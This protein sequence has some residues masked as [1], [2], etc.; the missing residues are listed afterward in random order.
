M[1]IR[2]VCLA[3]LALVFAAAPVSAND[4]IL[5][6]ALR[7]VLPNGAVVILNEK[8]EVPLVGFRVML[9][10]GAVTDPVG[11][12]GLAAL[13]A[14][15]LEK[16]AADLDAAAFAEAVDSVGGRLHASGG[17]EAITIAG[18][19]LA[20]DSGLMV[21]LLSDML[22]KPA[23]S[24]EEF[25]KLRER[26]INAIRAAKDSDPAELLPEY[27]DAYLFGDHPYG[28][29]SGGSEQSLAAITHADVQGFYERQMGGDRL[30]IVISGDIDAAAMQPVL[31][32]AF[33]DWRPAAGSL[34]E[35]PAPAPQP[36]GRLLLVDKPGAT[37]TYFWLGN[38]GVARDFDRRAE[39]EL[40][41]THFGGRFTS[42]LN[43]ALRVES[44]LTYGAGSYLMQPSRP[45]SVAISS[46]TR[47]DATVEAIDMAI[48]VLGRLHNSNFAAE[49]IDSARNYVLGQFPIQL[50]TAADLAAQ[51]AEL[52][53]YGLPAETIDGYGDAL[54]AA[55]PESI[56]AVI[57]D[58]YPLPEELVFV[59]IGDAEAIRE[60]VARYGEVTEIT[61]SLPVFRPATAAPR[62]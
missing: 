57:D 3:V 12:A 62:N 27:A 32:R 41:N 38:V 11:K 43:S 53:F 17:L 61:L 20:R 36:G 13:C 35:I 56:D 15:M 30:I 31:A 29:P 37:Q 22:R 2:P 7:T 26:R 28:R 54:H 48:G 8:P 9:R 21:E 39:L 49:T 1:M 55:T 23:L 25:R 18:D 51:F 16:G 47:T 10:S 4:A 46:F 58:V 19:F 6:A 44:G 59:L 52:E 5:P 24:E 33:G 60:D 45:G 34:P 42:M 40:A 50:E 14:E